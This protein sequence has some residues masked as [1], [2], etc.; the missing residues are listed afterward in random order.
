MP[1]TLPIA[2]LVALVALSPAIRADAASEPIRV[3]AH[4]P[5]MHGE[6]YG[7]VISGSGGSDQVTVRS[8]S[9]NTLVVSNP[10]G[11][12][13]EEGCRYGGVLVPPDA[14]GCQNVDQATATCSAPS[15]MH[16]QARLLG[17]TTRSVSSIRSSY[18]WPADVARIA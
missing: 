2:L 18:R 13:A 16:G 4:G 12:V 5:G 14:C 7:I 9:P 15:G 11:A 8:A 1:R 6:A 3:A 17:E 10:G